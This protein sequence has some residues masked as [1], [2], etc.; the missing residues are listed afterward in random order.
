MDNPPLRS[1]PGINVQFPWSRLI[2]SSKKTIETRH[3]PLP[4]KYKNVELALIETPGR[5]AFKAKIIAIVI[6]DNCFKYSSKQQW[7]DD[8]DKHLVNENDKL[9]G[10][11]IDKSKWAWRIKTVSMLSEPVDPPKP[12]G[13]VFSSDCAVPLDLLTRTIP[14]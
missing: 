13:I 12:R 3:Y 10:Y 4:E 14:K 6:F 11:R 7:A 5:E 9:F 8:Y 1:Y 2:V